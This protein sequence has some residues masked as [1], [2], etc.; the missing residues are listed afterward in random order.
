LTTAERWW[1]ALAGML[2]VASVLAWWSPATL[3]DWQPQ[4]AG[5]Q[6]WRAWTAAF[7]HWSGLH[8]AGNLAGIAVVG[9]W[10]S[11]PACHHTW[12]SR[13]SPPGR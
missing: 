9:A 3:I 4:L 8:L 5:S 13:G 12:P 10:A 7:V 2:A 1:P 11:L 6:P